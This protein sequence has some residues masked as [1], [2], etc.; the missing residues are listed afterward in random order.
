MVRIKVTYWD[1]ASS[2][3]VLVGIYEFEST[4]E[5]WDMIDKRFEDDKL[6]KHQYSYL[7]STVPM[8]RVSELGFE[9]QVVYFNDEEL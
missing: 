5:M 2:K 6:C 8:R 3:Y 7:V 4:L 1:D 9:Y